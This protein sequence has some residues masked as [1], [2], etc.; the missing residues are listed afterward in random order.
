MKNW[1]V[2]TASQENEHGAGLLIT[3]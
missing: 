1:N 3:A 2:V